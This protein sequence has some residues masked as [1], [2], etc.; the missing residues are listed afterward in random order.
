LGSNWCGTRQTGLLELGKCTTRFGNTKP[1]EIILEMA[2]PKSIAIVVID[3][4]FHDPAP[5]N[6]LENDLLAE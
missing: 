2:K 6:T 4:H 1:A 3:C 5:L